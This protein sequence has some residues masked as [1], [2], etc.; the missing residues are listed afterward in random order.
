M[1]RSILLSKGT[2]KAAI[3][4]LLCFLAYSE[5]HAA[6]VIETQSST[7]SFERFRKETDS[8]KILNHPQ[9][10]ARLKTLMGNKVSKYWD[11]TQLVEEPKISGDH[12]SITGGVRGLFTITESV[13]DLNMSTGKCCAGYLENG[14]L[15]VYGATNTS[16]L[17]KPVH[18]YVDDLAKR[19][20][21]FQG[22]QFE[23]AD[24][25]PAKAEQKSQPKAHLNLLTPTGTYQRKG[26]SAFDSATLDVLSLPNGKIQFSIV[27]NSGSHTGEA[28]GTVPIVNNHAVYSEGAAKIEMRFSGSTAIVSGNDSDLCGVG[29]TLLGSYK[30]TDDRKPKF[31]L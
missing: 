26:H 19:S 2:I 15:H 10:K 5:V 24:W 27:A 14:T 13:F 29:V 7:T 20:S 8:W 11:S 3:V 25:S 18:D 12:C 23:N 4:T 31:D 21:D 28:Q 22:T 30:K 16:D 1:I 6:P 17:P 9:I